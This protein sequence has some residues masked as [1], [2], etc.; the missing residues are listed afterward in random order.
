MPERAAARRSRQA[1]QVHV[2]PSCPTWPVH[3]A[4]IALALL[5]PVALPAAE[6]LVSGEGSGTDEDPYIVPRASCSINVDAVL[7]EPAWERALVLSL[8]YEVEPGENVPSPVETHVLLVY[9]SDNLYAAF[10]CYDP[11]P[12][13]V[14]ANVCDRDDVSS[15]DDWVALILDTF[16]DE[17][18]SFDVLVN[19]AGVQ[20]DFIETASGGGSWDAIWD[21]AGRRTEWGYAVELAVPFKQLRFQRTDGPQVWGF[22]A[23]RSY[24]RT[25]RHHIGVFPRDRGNNCYLCQAVKIAGFE[26]A[27]PGRNFEIAPTVTG[28]RTDVRED[29]PRGGFEAETKKAEFGVTAKWGMTPNLTLSTAVN[30]DFSQVEADAIQLDINRP[31][32][33]SYSERR[34]F[35][36]EGVDFFHTL[37]EAFY[38]RVVRDPSWGVKLSG[39]EGVHT[40]GVG[41]M[42]DEITNILIPGSQSSSGVSLDDESTD[43]ILRYKLDIGS[44][45]TLGAMVTDRRGENYRNTLAGVDFD[46]RPS[47]SDQFQGQLMWST[48]EY[49]SEVVEGREQPRGDLDDHFIA[50]EYDHDGRNTYVW[51]DYD[52]AGPDFRADLGFIPRVG[53]RNVE[54]GLLYTFY[55]EPVTWWSHVTPSFD[56][57]YYEDWDGRLLQKGNTLSFNFDGSLQSWGYAG[58]NFYQEGYSGSEYDLV[59]YNLSTGMRPTGW[60]YAELN[61][62]AGDRIDYA[63]GRLGRRLQV[64]SNVSVNLGSHT[65]AGLGHTYEHLDVDAGRLYTANISALEAR[66]NLNVRTFIRAILQYWDYRR[67]ASLYVDEVDKESTGLATQLLFSYKVNPQT[68]LFVGYAD[69]H[70]GGDDVDLT[71]NDRTFFLK[72]GYALTL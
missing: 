32:A 51:L 11:E 29:F 64:S 58:V 28:I 67:D 31:F 4:M 70:Y 2:H 37:K 49:P 38:S 34:P 7:N 21:S 71:Q 3:L 16:N 48:T 53:Y 72:V 5:V 66:H 65:A 40:V 13:A 52:N 43:S 27:M 1:R 6:A 25:Q 20:E 50:L 68:V 19:A 57:W 54:G 45:Y 46:L 44:D 9:D 42:R 10:R 56:F 63:N 62:A 18:R 30:P 47:Q 17:R 12:S 33:L 15:A 59:S 14:N 26:G 36:L 69:N 35:F 22:D 8:P 24:P 60:T 23:V 39:K 55:N 61:A 41:V